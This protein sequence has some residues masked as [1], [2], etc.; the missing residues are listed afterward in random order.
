MFIPLYFTFFSSFTVFMSVTFFNLHIN[1]LN[2]V[3]HS[4]SQWLTYSI[5]LINSLNIRFLSSTKFVQ[6]LNLW[7]P[8]FDH[9]FPSFDLQSTCFTQLILSSI[10]QIQLNFSFSSQ[11]SSPRQLH[12][13]KQFPSS[14][15][16]LGTFGSLCDHI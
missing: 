8:S 13:L 4:Y 1:H 16:K 3:I 15:N 5:L 12:C 2:C 14:S 10:L 9:Q 6:P 11:S 7:F